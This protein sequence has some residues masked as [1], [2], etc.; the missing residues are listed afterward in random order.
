VLLFVGLILVVV[1]AAAIV[2]AIIP[3]RCFPPRPQQ[4][5]LDARTIA[6]AVELYNS[7]NARCP[8]MTDLVDERILLPEKRLRDPWNVEFRIVCAGASILVESAG[9]E[10]KFGTADDLSNLNAVH[11]PKFLR[12]R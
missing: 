8:T 2:L 7:E 3:S 11:E 5:I 12:Q 1:A 4:A 9:P 10:R 6:S